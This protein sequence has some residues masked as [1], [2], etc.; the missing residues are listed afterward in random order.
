M[1]DIDS[2]IMKLFFVLSLLAIARATPAKRSSPVIYDGRAPL[3][4]TQASLDTSTGPYLTCVLAC[5]FYLSHAFDNRAQFTQCSQGQ[6][7]KRLSCTCSQPVG[8]A[9]PADEPIVFDFAGSRSAT[10]T[11]VEQ[12]STLFIFNRASHLHYN[13]Q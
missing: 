7:R 2:N 12:K 11:S 4:L 5:C 6:C 8:A 13:R 9:Q 10:D 3:S 1:C